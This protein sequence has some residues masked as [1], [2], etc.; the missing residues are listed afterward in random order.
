MRL[1]RRL[2]VLVAIALVPSLILTAYN[3]ARWRIFLEDE[4]YATALSEARF[5]AA[6][7]EQA[8]DNS[9]QLITAMSKYPSAS[10]DD[11]QCTSYFK[12]VIADTPVFR[13]AAIVDTGEKFHCSTFPF[14]Q[15]LAAEDRGSFYDT[16]KTG[17]VIVG[18]TAQGGTTRWPSIHI[19]MPYANSDGSIKG[20]AILVLDP[21]KWAES[22]PSYSWR[23]EYRLVVI[24]GKG[25]PVFSLPATDLEQAGAIAKSI[26][27]KIA[28]AASGTTDIKDATG[29][30]LIVGFAS[31][32]VAAGNLFTAAA[33]DRDQALAETSLINARGV[34]FDFIAMFLAVIGVWLAAYIMIDRPI[35]AIIRSARKREAGDTSAQFPKFRFSDE[36]GQLSAALTRMSGTIDE[37]LRQ[38]DLLLREVQHRV[39]NSLNLLSSLLDLQRRSSSSTASKQHLANAR[40]RVVAMGT[41]YRHLYQSHT[42]EHVE[43]SEF[44][45]TICSTS[46]AAY[47][48]TR[49]PSIKVDAEPLELTGSHA[50]SLGMLTHELITNAL[51]H[52]YPEGAP[53]AIQV[54]LKHE[55]DGSID[56]RVADRGRGLPDDFQIDAKS[57][58]LGMKVI[59]STVRQLGGTLEINR[60]NPGTEFAIHLPADI[61][62]RN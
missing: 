56:F 17:K 41:V 29:R 47:V 11:E 16:L 49:K 50:I 40:D 55:K 37:L 62:Q 8:I 19:W 32:D 36:F 44:L 34:A 61:E 20:A 22:L 45:D 39:M 46:E 14:P 9:R 27:P 18:T 5:T 48:G 21:E 2:S 26:F 58:S 30:S 28:D 25:S 38:K 7:L 13:E 6:E 52:A 43:F 57:S 33:I 54:T 42:L 59:A 60:L 12:S 4:T 3:A 51:K 23:P 35:R 53:G 10:V 1:R 31:P 24:D 15:A